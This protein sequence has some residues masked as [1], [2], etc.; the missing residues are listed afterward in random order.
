MGDLTGPSARARVALWMEINRGFSPFNIDQTRKDYK[1]YKKEV[2][3]KAHFID[4]VVRQGW[5][6]RAHVRLWKKGANKF[7]PGTFDAVSDVVF[8]NLEG[9]YS[10]FADG[11]KVPQGKRALPMLFERTF[12]DKES[13]TIS[14][15]RHGI[16]ITMCSTEK[17]YPSSEAHK[18]ARAWGS[19]S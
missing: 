3:E 10:T 18:M 19:E 4:F 9:K 7:A 17:G 13:L 15:T 16:K 11:P 12:G 2:G 6:P 1:S 5:I 8:R 14:P